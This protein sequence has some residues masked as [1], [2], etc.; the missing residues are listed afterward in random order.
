RV[1][2]MV[3]VKTCCCGCSLRTGTII[4]GYICAIECLSSII[5]DTT[6]GIFFFLHAAFFISSHLL[7][8]A[9]RQ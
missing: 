3:R 1:I 6:P 4:I 8:A 2:K 9:A 5:L 7:I